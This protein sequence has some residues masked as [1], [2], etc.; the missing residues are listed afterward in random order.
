MPL[1]FM[2][3][4]LGSAPAGDPTPRRTTQMALL[5]SA[6]LSQARSDLRICLP[7]EAGSGAA[8][9]SSTPDTTRHASY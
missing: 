9:L 3:Q 2:P 5:I 8:M 7:T 1:C 6:T 4:I